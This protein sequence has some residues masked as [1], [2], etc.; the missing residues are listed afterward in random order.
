MASVS[1]IVGRANV[2]RKTFYR[3]FA[4]K[5]E[6]GDCAAQL[7]FDQALA[8][9]RAACRAQRDPALRIASAASAFVAHAGERPE[10]AR[11]YVA[12]PVI[13]ALPALARAITSGENVIDRRSPAS[14]RIGEL[15]AGDDPVEALVVAA[16]HEDRV[17]L[18]ALTDVAPVAELASAALAGGVRAVLERTGDLVAAR[19]AQPAGRARAELPRAP[20]GRDGGRDPGGARPPPP[21]ADVAAAAPA[22]RAAARRGRSAGGSARSR[23]QLG[24]RRREL[25]LDE[26]ETIVSNR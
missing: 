24:S 25:T 12:E 7:A 1:E 3:L 15:D 14:L 10:R 13:R 16:V 8:Q 6:V 22:G 18:I 9:M 5:D 23:D 19:T 11:L 26:M 21:V 4:G 2:S 20:S 17:A